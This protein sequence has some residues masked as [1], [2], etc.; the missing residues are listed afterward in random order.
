MTKTELVYQAKANGYLFIQD[1]AGIINVF[2]ANAT[3]KEIDTASGCIFRTSAKCTNKKDFEIE[4]IY[5][6]EKIANL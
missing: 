5:I 6:A 2:D 1:Q 3:Q 4:I